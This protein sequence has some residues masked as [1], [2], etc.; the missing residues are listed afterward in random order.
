MNTGRRGWSSRVLPTLFVAIFVLVQVAALSH[1]LE[2]VFR[3]HDEPCDLHI[4]AAHIVMATAPEP[5]VPAA[6]M[7]AADP[8]LPLLDAPMASPLAPSGARS[9]PL[10]V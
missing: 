7:C 10:F 2:H 8:V 4:V 5:A 9:P 1:E 3:Q 6:L